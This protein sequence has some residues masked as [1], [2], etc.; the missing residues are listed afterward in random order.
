M[1]APGSQLSQVTVLLSTWLPAVSPASLLGH[2][3]EVASEIT[4]W[5]IG[6][7]HG[8]SLKQQLSLGFQSLQGEC[9]SHWALTSLVGGA[10]GIFKRWM[11]DR[12]HLDLSHVTNV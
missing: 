7:G 9:S 3:P 4:A 11:M 2:F 1:S 5:K 12:Y 8:I 10:N 6:Q